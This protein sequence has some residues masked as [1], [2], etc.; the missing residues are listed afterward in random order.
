LVS[1]ALARSLDWQ[2]LADVLTRQVP[3]LM[4]FRGAQLQMGELTS[5]PLAPRSSRSCNSPSAAK[6]THARCGW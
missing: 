3:A 5:P 4:Q 2:E 1:A 6:D